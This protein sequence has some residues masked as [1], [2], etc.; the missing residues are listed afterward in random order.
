[1]AINCARGVSR[2]VASMGVS[3]NGIIA[4]LTFLIHSINRNCRMP[5]R[6]QSWSQ[7]SVLFSLFMYKFIVSCYYWPATEL[8]LRLRTLNISQQFAE[9]GADFSDSK[10]GRLTT[11]DK[12]AST[13]ERRTMRRLRAKCEVELVANLSFLDT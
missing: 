7:H 8:G 2:S 11:L 5:K 10:I 3:E 4:V 1:M 6:Q 9:T 13:I 12:L